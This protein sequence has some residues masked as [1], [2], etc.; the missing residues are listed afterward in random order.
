LAAGLADGIHWPFVQQETTFWRK[1]LW[2]QVGGLDMKLKL[3]GDWDLWV[4]FAQITSLT[5]VH[6]QLGAF[7]VRPGQQSSNIRAYRSEMDWLAT[8]L[9]RKLALRHKSLCGASLTSIPWAVQGGEEVWQLR[10]RACGLPARFM[11]SVLNVLPVPSLSLIKIF[12]K[13]W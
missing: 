1:R 5:H 9:D 12:H 11:A 8:P 3:A 4:R 6:R 2:D 7:Y 10:E 13:L